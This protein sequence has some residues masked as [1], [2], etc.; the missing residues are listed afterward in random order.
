MQKLQAAFAKLKEPDAC[1]RNQ[2]CPSLILPQE[3]FQA[4][5]IFFQGTLFYIVLNNIFTSVPVAI[6]LSG[7]KNRSIRY[8]APDA[9][10]AV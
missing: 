4:A 7:I 5:K 9:G 1:W 3:L 2:P 6:F 10:Q 8:L